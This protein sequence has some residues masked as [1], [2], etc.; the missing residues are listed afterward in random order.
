VTF[1]GKCGEVKLFCRCVRQTLL[2]F[3][4]VA[5]I[6]GCAALS[7][8]HSPVGEY[9]MG[10]EDA[11]L[12]H[13]HNHPDGSLPPTIIVDFN[14]EAKDFGACSTVAGVRYITIYVG[15]IMKHARTPREGRLLI[16]EVLAHELGHAAL[17]CTDQDHRFMGGGK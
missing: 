8:Q 14:P 9:L 4:A 15:A 17:T 2:A 1:C 3:C 5:F 6:Y 16:A 7:E 11:L 10:V 13:A 12:E